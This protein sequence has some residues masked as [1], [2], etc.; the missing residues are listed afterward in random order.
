MSA[1]RTIL[2]GKGSTVHYVGPE[3]SVLE[4][5]GRMCRQSH[6]RAPRRGA[7]RGNWHHLR[8]RHHDAPRPR[9]A[10][11]GE[12]TRRGHHDEERPL[13]RP[14]PGARAGDGPDDGAPGPPPPRRRGPNRRSGCVS[15]RRSRPL[16]EPQPGLRDPL[17]LRLRATVFIPDS[18]LTVGLTCSPHGGPFPS[19]PRA[20][21]RAHARH[22]RP[23][24]QDRARAAPRGVTQER[25]AAAREGRLRPDAARS[26]HR[27]LGAAREDA[28]VPGL[29]APGH[30]PRRRVHRDGRRPDGQERLAPAPLARGGRGVGEDVHRSG[31]QDPRPRRRRR[32]APTPSG[33]TSSRRSRSSSSWRR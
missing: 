12:H 17:A 18:S 33:S 1:L 19:R 16:G 9:E 8:A 31:L 6:R 5:V 27:P 29:R 3:V 22:R 14:E 23:A 4:A 10:R 2:E 32:S 20:D 28:A 21:G 13:H 7:R 24:R 15:H 30:P 25:Q 11:P 26:P